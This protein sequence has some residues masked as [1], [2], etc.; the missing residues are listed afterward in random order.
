MRPMQSALPGQSCALR[1]T[2]TCLAHVHA[3]LAAPSFSV[4]VF[5]RIAHT[6]L[7]HDA[8]GMADS[9]ESLDQAGSLHG[10]CTNRTFLIMW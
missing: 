10:C 8:V 3:C 6:V 1:L 4:C 7:H 9:S 5:C 2:G